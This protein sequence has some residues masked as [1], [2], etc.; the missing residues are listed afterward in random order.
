V[1]KL[2]ACL[3]MGLMS[4][5]CTIIHGRHQDVGMSSAPPGAK[6]YV[7]SVYVGTT[8]IVVPIKRGD[9]HVV[10]LEKDGYVPFD[11]TLTHKVSGWVWGNIAF[12]GLIGLGVDAA[13]GSLY[14]IYPEQ[15]TGTLERDSIQKSVL[16]T[17]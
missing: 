12:G 3:L 11:A 1:K 5:C 13:A 7:D 16:L 10:R 8:P 17:H 2:F 15:I 4:G 14:N 9:T 6:V